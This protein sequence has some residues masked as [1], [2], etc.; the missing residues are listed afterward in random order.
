MLEFLEQFTIRCTYHFSKR[1]WQFWD[2]AQ[3]M[4]FFVK[5]AFPLKEWKFTLLR[6]KIHPLRVKFNSFLSEIVFT[7]KRKWTFHSVTL[8]LLLE[9]HHAYF[10]FIL[11]GISDPTSIYNSPWC[12]CKG[13]CILT[14]K[15]KRYLLLR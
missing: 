3:N 6:V 11:G 12:K 14:R 10:A 2:I 13:L 7:F 9:L 8:I 5:G 4:L 15:S 1:C